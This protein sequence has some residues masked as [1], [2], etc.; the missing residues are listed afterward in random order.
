[1][2]KP[3]ATEY[4]LRR[5]SR[6]AVCDQTLASLHSSI[7]PA[8]GRFC[9]CKGA[10]PKILPITTSSHSLGRESP[11]EADLLGPAEKTGPFRKGRQ[12]TRFRGRGSRNL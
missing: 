3:D 5:I 4:S 6:A 11:N 2:R 10:G 7:G 9:H 1:M 8:L 12:E